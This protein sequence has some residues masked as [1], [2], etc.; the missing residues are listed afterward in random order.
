MDENN[1][2]Y[3]SYS[4]PKKPCILHF[5]AIARIFAGLA[6]A[7]CIAQYITK[8]VSEYKG[9]KLQF[10]WQQFQVYAIAGVNILYSLTLVISACC[11]SLSSAK[12]WLNYKAAF[13]CKPFMV[14]F[15]MLYVAVAQSPATLFIK[16]DINNQIES[17]FVLINM[18][19]CAIIFLFGLFSP[20]KKTE[21]SNYYLAMGFNVDYFS[22]GI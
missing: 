10:K 20:C 21:V 17:S 14:C 6:G 8:I 16:G 19:S 3:S 1:Q 13:L 12:Q 5:Q 15:V 22:F 18:C 7:S 9:H 4:K 2:Q 11:K